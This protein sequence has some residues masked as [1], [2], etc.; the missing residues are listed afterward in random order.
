MNRF[1]TSRAVQQ[2][3]DIFNYDAL[4]LSLTYTSPTSG[5]AIDL[6]AWKFE[7]FLEY[8]GQR[9]AT[10]TILPSEMTTTYLAKTGADDNVLNM[11]AMWEDIRDNKITVKGEYKLIQLATD[12]DGNKY[13]QVVYLINAG[14]Y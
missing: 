5:G 10:Y 9:K 8:A 4:P 11:Q 12:A 14:N 7:F 13:V 3:V 2:P 1:N 6:T